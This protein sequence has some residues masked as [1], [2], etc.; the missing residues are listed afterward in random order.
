MFKFSDDMT[1]GGMIP[2]IPINDYHAGPGVSKSQLGKFAQSPAH[3]KASLGRVAPESTAL[4][5]GR[6]AH[7]FILEPDADDVLVA[8]DVNKRTKAGR[9]E[10][11]LFTA[12]AE[13]AGKTVVTREEMETLRGMRDSVYY[14]PAAQRLLFAHG[15]RAMV[16]HSAYWYDLQSGELCRCRPDFLRPDFIAVD[17]KTTDDASPWAFA[18]S[19]SKFRYYLQ[20]A[21]Y[22]DGIKAATGEKVQSFVFVAVEKAPPYAVAVYQL[23]DQGVETGRAEYRRLLLDLADCKIKNYWPGYSDRVE[24]I[25]LPKWAV[26]EALNG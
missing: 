19:I 20:A 2:G 18:R 10:W 4:R 1:T 7:S 17:L 23:D 12:E 21:F 3:Y 11:E 24:T 6:A 15:G 5:L 22:S 25:S 26:E 16:E 8:P 9:E 13:A 14:H